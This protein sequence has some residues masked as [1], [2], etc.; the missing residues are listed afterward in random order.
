VRGLYEGT[1]DG[2]MG[3]GYSGSDFI[4]VYSG[5]SRAS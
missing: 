3:S 1:I 4:S 2:R 5:D